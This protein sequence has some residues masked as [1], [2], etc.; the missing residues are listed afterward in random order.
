MKTKVRISSDY[1]G[2]RFG[3]GDEGYIDGYVRCKNDLPCAVVIV[4]EKIDFVP[5]DSL[6]V[7]KQ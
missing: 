4:G 2:D 7:I 5:V 1:P 6:T 3:I